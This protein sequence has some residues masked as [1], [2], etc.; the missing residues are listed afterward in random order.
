MHLKITFAK[1]SA[2]LFKRRWF[3]WK[4]TSENLHH[5]CCYSLV[6]LR[7]TCSLVINVRHSVCG[8]VL[9]SPLTIT[10][11]RQCAMHDEWFMMTSS[12]GHFPHYWPFVRRLRRSPVN[13]PHKGQ[14]CGALM[15]FFYLRLN[16][17][18]SKQS[19]GWWFEKPSPLGVIARG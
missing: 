10:W 12:N 14:W 17:R 7:H 15:F 1:T 9:S 3:N 11:N 18:S 16:K 19:W 2:I 5:A 13:S 6:F 8:H 4:W